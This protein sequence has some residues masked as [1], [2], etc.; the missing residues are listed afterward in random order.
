MYLCCSL[1][2]SRLLREASLIKPV[3]LADIRL[4]WPQLKYGHNKKGKA[5]KQE[6]KEG[7]KRAKRAKVEFPSRINGEFKRV[8]VGLVATPCLTPVI[9]DGKCGGL[10]VCLSL[11]QL[12]PEQKK[13]V[14]DIQEELARQGQ[15]GQE[16]TDNESDDDGSGENGED[17]MHE[18]SADRESMPRYGNTAPAASIDELRCVAV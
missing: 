16:D 11:L 18:P 9:M 15:A 13:T 12:D 2:L 14:L 7:S 17:E 3:C 4:L 8:F 5:P 6:I 1:N 10:L